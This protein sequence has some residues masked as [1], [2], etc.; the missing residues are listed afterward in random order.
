MPKRRA[1][2]NNNGGR[3]VIEEVEDQLVPYDPAVGGQVSVYDNDDS[4]K[5][6]DLWIDEEA[7]RI[8][9]PKKKT[10]KDGKKSGKDGITL[11]DAKKY[12]DAGKKAYKWAQESGAIDVV[13]DAISYGINWLSNGGQYVD[14]KKDIHRFL[15]PQE[16]AELDMLL[17]DSTGT[18]VGGAGDY[19]GNYKKFYSKPENKGKSKSDFDAYMRRQRAQIQEQIQKYGELASIRAQ[20][21]EWEKDANNNVPPYQPNQ[22]GDDTKEFLDPKTDPKERAKEYN[23]TAEKLQDGTIPGSTFV[24]PRKKRGPRSNKRGPRSKKY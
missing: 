14:P 20:Q 1:V 7:D 6:V 3:V 4:K 9:P 19:W 18:L 2:Y 8:K 23:N 12:Y 15:T 11:D 24:E 21:Q 13:K 17:K 10:K 16:S 5:Q 22:S